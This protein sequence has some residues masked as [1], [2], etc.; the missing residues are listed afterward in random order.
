MN[1]YQILEQNQRFKGFLDSEENL[2]F[3][4]NRLLL[5]RFAM[6]KHLAL[7]ST[8]FEIIRANIIIRSIKNKKAI[9]D[10][11]RFA[12][13]NDDVIKREKDLAFF[14][15]FIREKIVDLPYA[16]DDKTRLCVPIFNRMINQI[17]SEEFEKL[18]IS[19]YD[20]I[21]EQFETLVIDPFEIYN[22]ILYDSLFT[23]FVKV[24]SD[25][26]IMAVFHYDFQAIYFI[27]KQGRLDNKIA[28]FD[29]GIRHPDYHHLLERIR[30]VI[31]AYVANDKDTMLKALADKKLIS[32]KLI[33]RIRSED[34][35]FR[36]ALIRKIK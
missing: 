9:E 1:L 27:D 3:L 24:Y 13:N 22:F 21:V 10:A 16:T 34:Y 28:L 25:D 2:F 11:V 14:R 29:R 6:Y 35:R 19:P 15:R 23:Q 33:S 30:P 4:K 18:L 26:N 20:K 12:V 5:E 32:E 17:Y 36:M 8:D 7:A 31:A